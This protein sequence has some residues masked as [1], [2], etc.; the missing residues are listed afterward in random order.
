[1]DI[2]WFI[3]CIVGTG[4]SVWLIKSGAIDRWAGKVKEKAKRNGFNV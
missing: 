4:I 1:M 3:A 2:F